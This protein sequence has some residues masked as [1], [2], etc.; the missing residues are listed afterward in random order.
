[1]EQKRSE[2]TI[3]VASYSGDRIP[4]APLAAASCTKPQYLYRPADGGGFII[5]S[6]VYGD[7]VYGRMREHVN[8]VGLAAI[9]DDARRIIA[10]LAHTA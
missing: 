6:V 8:F 1:M 2:H 9:E 5:E 7:V 10:A 3:S 4:P